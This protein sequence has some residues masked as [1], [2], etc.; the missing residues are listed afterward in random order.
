[1]IYR[2]AVKE[3]YIG[4]YFGGESDLTEAYESFIGGDDTD[5]DNSSIEF[6]NTNVTIEGDNDD[7]GEFTIINVQEESDSSSSNSSSSESSSSDS[8]DESSSELCIKGESCIEELEFLPK[9]QATF[10]IKP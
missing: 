3:D 4:G 2:M 8:D 5:T 10:N 1:M 6:I 9:L 7:D